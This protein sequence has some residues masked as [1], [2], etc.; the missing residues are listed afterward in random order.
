MSDVPGGDEFDE[1]L[2]GPHLPAHIYIHV[3]FCRAKCSYCD[4]YSVD[5]TSDDVIK[6]YVLGV[7]AEMESWQRSGVTGLVETV[8]L[9][10]GTPTAIGGEA[11]R[12][13]ALAGRR[14]PV[15]PDAEITVEANPDSLGRELLESL[16]EVGVTRISL[17]VQSYIPHETAILGRV[18]TVEQALEAARLVN[19]AGLELSIDLMCGIPGQTAATWGETLEKAVSSGASHFSVYPLTLESGTPL[20]VAVGTGLV[21]PPDEDFSAELMAFAEDYLKAE[22]IERYETANYARVGH[23]CRHNMAYW[24]GRTYA[25]LGPAAHGMLDAAT[26]ASTLGVLEE[27]KVR[28]RVGNVADLQRWESGATPTVEWLDEAQAAREDAMLGLRLTR[29]IDDRLASRA[30]V[31]HVLEALEERGLVAHAGGRWKTTHRGWLLGNEVFSAVWE[32]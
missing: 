23:E 21:S 8:Y 29:G 2:A 10:G 1:G 15:R 3:P 24:S 6:W 28:A 30:G 31:E 18:H 32:G 20:D 25:G 5:E 12:L 27:G 14:F 16:A 11:V 13:V 9:G 17:G 4:F 26:A 19:R 22:G 7:H